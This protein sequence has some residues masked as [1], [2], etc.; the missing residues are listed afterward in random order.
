MPNGTEQAVGDPPYRERRRDSRSMPFRESTFKTYFLVGT[1]LIVC[2]LILYT[3]I[4]VINPMRRELSEEARILADL[5]GSASQ[6]VTA[7]DAE[8]ALILEKVIKRISFPIVLTS[9]DGEPHAWRN[10]GIPL[11]DTTAAARRQIKEMVKRMDRRNDPIAFGFAGLLGIVGYVHYDDSRL[12]SRIWWLPIVEIAVVFL[13]VLVGLVSFRNIK[14]IEQRSIW[15]GMAKETAHQLGTP[16]SSLSGWLELMRT[17]L[18]SHIG[19]ERRI[20]G[21]KVT[22]IIDEMQHDMHRLNKI[23]S[24]FSRIGS[25]PEL[26]PGDVT[27]VV[28]ETVAYFQNRLPHFGRQIRIEEQYEPVDPHPMNRELLG[29]AF[30]NLLKNAIDAIDRQ[31]GLITVTVRPCAQR[32]GVEIEVRDN[33]KGMNPQVQKRAFLA[34]YTT[35]QMGWGLGLTFV[36][37]IVEDY[38]HGRVS[39]RE[40]IPGRGTTVAIALLG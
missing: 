16:L 18:D 24:R 22:G 29:W 14:E 26:R 3:Q 30:E 15:A 36:K 21:R 1:I 4:S 27:E 19:H 9:A 5:I 25:V 35:K 33:G 32:P 2:A 11:S 20:G 31:D 40:S 13:F 28:A 37:R 12:I 23:A 39:I 10:V 8:L 38:H 7:S 6:G 17:E 34:G